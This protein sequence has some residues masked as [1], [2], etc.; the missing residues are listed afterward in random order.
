MPVKHRYVTSGCN[1]SADAC[2]VVMLEEKST[3]P[4]A[5]A[6]GG[7]TR[8]L[9]EPL[10]ATEQLASGDGSLRRGVGLGHG[11]ERCGLCRKPGLFPKFPRGIKGSRK[12]QPPQKQMTRAGA[13]QPSE[14][15]GT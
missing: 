8:L 11:M 5:N 6:Q 10:R 14:S 7:L 1:V 2:K 9:P 3:N 13:L 15:L 12:L 4:T